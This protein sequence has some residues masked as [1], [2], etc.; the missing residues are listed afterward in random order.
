MLEGKK[1]W[2]GKKIILRSCS[3]HYWGKKQ[4]HK[5]L[6]N[7]EKTSR[8]SNHDVQNIECRCW[9]DYKHEHSDVGSVPGNVR[10]NCARLASTE[11][12]L[13]PEH[14]HALCFFKDTGIPQRKLHCPT[15]AGAFFPLSHFASWIFF[16]LISLRGKSLWATNMIKSFREISKWV[17]RVL[18]EQLQYCIWKETSKVIVDLNRLTA[19]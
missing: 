9:V 5:I 1:R 12:I 8:F 16:K 18:I 3:E 10:K 2:V 7:L 4:K 19:V 13:I 11:N 14:V 17:Q 15:K 6:K